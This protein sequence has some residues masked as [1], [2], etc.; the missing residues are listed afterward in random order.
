MAPTFPAMISRHFFAAILLA[1]GPARA[2]WVADAILQ[3]PA[4]AV[5]NTFGND[6]LLEGTTLIAGAPGTV[7][8]GKGSVGAVYIFDAN[9]A[10]VWGFTQKLSFASEA[11]NSNIGRK[12][13]MESN[14]LLVSTRTVSEGRVEVYQRTVP[15]GQWNLQQTLTGDANDEYF[16][17]G[18]G[19][20]GNTVA[21]GADNAAH[22]DGQRRGAVYL[23]SR[24]GP[25]SSWTRAGK[26]LAPADLR[27]G[28]NFGSS[29]VM[30]GDWLAVNA[31]ND[32][33]A[34]PGIAQ[35]WRGVTRLYRGSGGS[36]S[37]HSRIEPDT[38]KARET[39]WESTALRDGVLV[40]G[41]SNDENPVS[42]FQ[43]LGAAF[44]YRF[45]AGSGTWSAQQKIV[46][47]PRENTVSFGTSASVD[48]GR[49][50]IGASYAG[51]IGAFCTYTRDGAGLWALE[52]HLQHP[53]LAS[54]AFYGWRVRYLGGRL[55]VT[56]LNP[57]AGSGGAVFL[58]HWDSPLFTAWQTAN[59][60]AAQLADPAISGA[61]AD[62]DRDGLLNLIEAHFGSAPLSSGA[63]PWSAQRS[64][65]SFLLTWPEVAVSPGTT[66]TPQWSPDLQT[67]L[68]SGESAPGIA[69]RT[70]TVTTPVVR[71][72]Q[73]SMPSS[74]LTRAH[75]R[76]KI[77]QN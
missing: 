75:L 68:A 52:G 50:V 20:R 11:A 48:G 14:T 39:G 42:P 63:P 16:G 13:A 32:G 44:A 43:V 29:L 33:T 74:G 2:A 4:D 41:A 55:A 53:G 77:S 7:E 54:Q 64:G 47:S 40:I 67:W 35:G 51:T 57:V 62:P 31:R 49:L 65:T 9:A 27:I 26:I 25:A 5:G 76:L 6:L 71:Q 18:V 66:A 15:G 12:I 61:L 46:T 36:F 60:S 3:A 37:L 73:A 19:M 56:S 30:D 70:I 28:G 17:N 72:R 45:D 59:F 24:S 58:Y 10:G 38:Y 69:A 21:V 22:P 1:A 23:F 8:D 34:N